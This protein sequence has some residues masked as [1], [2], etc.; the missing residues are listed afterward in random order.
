MRSVRGSLSDS[1]EMLESIREVTRIANDMVRSNAKY[2]DD[3]RQNQQQTDE[4]FSR[5]A[6]SVEQMD[7][8]SRQQ[9]NYL[10]SVSAMQAEVAR[11]IDQ[12]NASLNSFTKRVAEDSANASTGMLKAA[13]ELRATGETMREIH[14]DCTDAITA[15]LKMTL[16]SYQDYVNQFTQRVDYLAGSISDSLSHMP[17][18]VSDTS[19]QFLDQVDR[20]SDTLMQAQRVL[21]ETVARLYGDQRSRH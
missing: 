19:N 17:Q 15:E 4:A 11:S 3:L 21:N 7:L 1:A 8:I 10:K 16:D 9:A 5:V 14:K 20:L 2:I 13:A 12:M 6:S 18:A